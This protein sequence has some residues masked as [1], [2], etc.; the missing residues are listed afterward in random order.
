M[1]DRDRLYADVDELARGG[2]LLDMLHELLPAQ[3]SRAGSDGGTRQKVSGSPPPW[4]SEVA[5]VLFTIH[6]AARGTETSLRLRKGFSRLSR[7][8]SDGN[9]RDCLRRLPALA[10]GCG[11]DAASEVGS[12]VASWVRQARQ[13]S[14]I[15]LADKWEPLPRR[16]GTLPP[17]CPHCERFSLRMNKAAGEV[18]CLTRFCVDDDGCRTVARMEIGAYS[19]EASI[20]FG[21][22][23]Q[24]VYTEGE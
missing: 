14:D 21:D 8:G 3:V 4:H 22:G 16:P 20:V 19:G 6:A 2:G 10:E 24:V 11:D 9:T 7:G 5:G 18:R 13:L 1:T 23:R 15:G 17:V 12:L